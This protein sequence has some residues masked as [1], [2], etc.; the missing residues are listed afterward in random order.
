MPPP[1]DR[2]LLLTGA[3]GLAVPVQE[4]ADLIGGQVQVEVHRAGLPRVGLEPDRFVELRGVRRARG[5][6]W[7]AGAVGATEP[8][9]R[10][11]EAKA[12]ERSSG[13]A[14]S[15]AAG[16]RHALPGPSPE[17]SPEC[18][19]KRPAPSPVDALTLAGVVWTLAGVART[20]AGTLAGMPTGS[21]PR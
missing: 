5:A 15:S 1:L 21:N 6:A 17:P 10:R 3:S 12:T 20:L 18:P 14:N 9:A 7:L 4:V 2:A 19:I 11:V 8:T 13:T 16:A